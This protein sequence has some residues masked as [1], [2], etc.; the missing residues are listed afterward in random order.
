M[1]RFP[2]VSFSKCNNREGGK[3]HDDT[4]MIYRPLLEANV[5]NEPDAKTT[6]EALGDHGNSL[7]EEFNRIRNEIEM[8]PAWMSWSVYG[9]LKKVSEK[10]AKAEEQAT[11]LYNQF[12]NEM[13]QT[14]IVI[15]AAIASSMAAVGVQATN[16]L[17]ELVNASQISGRNIL[18]MLRVQEASQSVA[19]IVERKYAY[20]FG[21]ISLYAAILSIVL[22]AIGA[23]PT[24][25]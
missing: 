19:A 20:A 2:P 16:Q 1:N 17:V 6:L 8:I 12:R 15:P 24:L 10:R 23:Y 4:P 5:A 25:K 7:A 14:K 9:S 3:F 11:Q 21:F 18:A 22:G 13:S